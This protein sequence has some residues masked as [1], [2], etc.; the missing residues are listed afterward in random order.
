MVGNPKTTLLAGAALATMFA[1]S[2]A[3]AQTPVPVQSTPAPVNGADQ[4]AGPGAAEIIVTANKREQNINKVGLSI[5]ALPAAALT[6]RKITSLADIASAVPGLA[7]ARSAAN[8]PILTLR[9][10][11]FNQT[12]LG[13]Y[14]AVSLYV[15]Q[16]PLP[17]P[18]LGSHSAFDLERIEVLKGPQGTL[19]GQNS[20]GGAI[21]YIA[22]KPTSTTQGGIDLSY[23]R[24]N[25]IEGTAY[26]SGPIT[27]N[28]RARVAVNGV[29]SDGWQISTT[30]PYDRNGSQSYIA[31]R[32]LLDWTPT[33]RVRISLNANG[34]IDKSQPLASQFIAL[35]PQV[36]AYVKPEE[37]TVP[38]SPQDPRAADWND[39]S[40]RPKG[41]RKFFQTALR[42][43][44]DLTDVITLTSITSYDH[45]TQRQATDYDGTA[46]HITDLQINGHLRSFNQ[47]LRLSNGAHSAF[48]WVLG[49]N[50]ER[51]SAFD[52][53]TSHVGND[54]ASNPTLFNF[55]QSEQTTKQQIRNY[56]AFG[57]AE[58]DLTS[59]LTLKAGVR[60]T[61]SHNDGTLC[62]VDAGDG[63]V[64]ALFNYF[65]SFAGVPFTPIG[66]TGPRYGRCYSLTAAGVPRGDPTRETLAEHNVS[67][68]VGIDYKLSPDA[69]LYANISRGYKAGSFPVLAATADSQNTPVTQEYVTSYEAGIKVGLFDRRVH[70][71]AAGFYYD[72]RNKQI[73]GKELDPTFGPEEALVNVPKSRI[74]GFDGDITVNAARGLTLAGALTYLNSRVLRYAG[75]NQF[76]VF[77]NFAGSN[78]PFTPKW[79]YSFNADYRI[80]T[81]DGGSP[82]VGVT[83]N[84]RS[85]QDAAL[86]GSTLTIPNIQG[87]RILPGLVYPFVTNPYATVDARLGY[88]ARG[89]AWKVMLYGKNIFNKYYW[90]N[91][92]TQSDSTQRQVGLPATYGVQFS[93]KFR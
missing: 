49:G 33:D 78:L 5:T 32:L 40:L 53:E 14:P 88:E 61:N 91:V 86:L 1:A 22:A 27:S 41:D 16:A 6:E 64:A 19:F 10:I 83:I 85:K 46:L 84:G 56:A 54:S 29:N 59:K 34:W 7:F 92:T 13:V 17:F 71:N 72:Y 52:D 67:W 69:L 4:S 66:S 23:G 12:A 47:E 58:Y 87:T 43:D 31:G 15:D 38:F 44:V 76:G 42:A 57:N 89:G 9:G 68:R 11:G 81:A 79:N 18:V 48:R 26:L 20:T 63:L 73:L 55:Y 50:Y 65:G 45:F 70:I 62:D 21:N 51:S 25:D 60:Y 77:T 24:F 36:P 82:F 75:P 35:Y 93:I 37:L 90:N 28:L 74:Y 3:Y 30:R 80:D 8:T 2:Q 39:D